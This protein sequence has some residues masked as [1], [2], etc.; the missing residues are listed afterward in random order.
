MQVFLNIAKNSQRA[1]EP[2]ARKQLVVR[3]SVEGNQVAIR[4]IDSG[5]GPA[6]PEALFQP[7]QPGAQASG[8]GLYLS[9]TF[10]RAFRGELQYEP[11]PRG[12]CFTV[13]L[14]AVPDN[15]DDRDFAEES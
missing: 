11:Q 8:L 6:N 3:T 13:L 7:F 2:Q 10:V 9:R 12:C 14:A 4:F 5:P 1:L 15:E